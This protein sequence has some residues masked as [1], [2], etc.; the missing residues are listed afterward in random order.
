M[1]SKQE[2][3][4]VTLWV[5]LL[6]ERAPRGHVDSQEEKHVIQT[7]SHPLQPSQSHPPRR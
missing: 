6:V 3:Q 5:G 1:L 4:G 7:R 2:P